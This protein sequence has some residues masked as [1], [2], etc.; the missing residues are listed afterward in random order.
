MNWYVHNY[1]SSPR[2]IISMYYFRNIHVYVY[3]GLISQLQFFRLSL[4]TMEEIQ[5]ESKTN[6][7][8]MQVL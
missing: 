5:H 2:P 1:Y 3:S 6:Y 4:G 7:P 8:F